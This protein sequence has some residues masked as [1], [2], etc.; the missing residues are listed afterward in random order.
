MSYSPGQPPSVTRQLQHSNS[1]RSIYKSIYLSALHCRWSLDPSIACT[2]W[3][4][5][6]RTKGFLLEEDTSSCFALDCSALLCCVSAER[7]PFYNS[8]L[9]DLQHIHICDTSNPHIC[10]YR[11][12][13]LVSL[14]VCVHVVLV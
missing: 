13:G 2:R 7:Y 12:Q 10:D 11:M 6:C 8:Y 14:K 9:D 4:R 3:P 1:I 5:S